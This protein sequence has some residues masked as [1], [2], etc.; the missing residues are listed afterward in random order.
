MLY[1]AP[2][3]SLRNARVRP[4]GASEGAFTAGNEAKWDSRPWRPSKNPERG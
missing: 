1:R 4:R 3:Q 2:A